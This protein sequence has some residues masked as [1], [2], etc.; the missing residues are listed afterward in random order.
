MRD[1]AV[2]SSDRSFLYLVSLRIL[3]DFILP[4]IKRMVGRVST[5]D[6]MWKQENGGAQVRVNQLNQIL[7]NQKCT[8]EHQT[9]NEY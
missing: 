1:V 4:N 9:D 6:I 8:R 3:V 5:N 2:S 7:K